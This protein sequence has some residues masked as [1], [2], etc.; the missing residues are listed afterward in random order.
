MKTYTVCPSCGSIHG[1]ALGR[2]G[3][4]RCGSCQ[5]ALTAFQDGISA[6]DGA[7]LAALI[8]GSPLPVAVDCWAPGCGP[9]RM[10]APTFQEASRSLAGKLAFAKLNTEVD[11]SAGGRFNIH[12]IPTLLLFHGGQELDRI[13]GALSLDPYLQWLEHGLRP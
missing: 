6:L 4:P 1:V 5:A 8:A 12:A 9:C 11:T 10:F 7:Q 13:S 2:E 3:S